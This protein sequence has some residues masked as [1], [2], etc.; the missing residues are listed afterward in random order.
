MQ[1]FRSLKF[2]K[3]PSEIVMNV[4]EQFLGSTLSCVVVT[5]S[6]EPASAP[7]FLSAPIVL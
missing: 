1:L 3:M 7:F 5:P 2:W 4:F 6:S